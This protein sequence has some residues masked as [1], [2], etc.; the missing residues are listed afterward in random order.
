MQKMIKG[1][2]RVRLDT[3]AAEMLP[4]VARSAGSLS[5]Y[6]YFCESFHV[7]TISPAGVMTVRECLWNADP[8]H[9]NDPV[10]WGSAVAVRLGASYS[11]N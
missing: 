7:A 3:A 4:R 10:R 6:Q 5:I 2:T 9:P 11:T 1:Y 8:L